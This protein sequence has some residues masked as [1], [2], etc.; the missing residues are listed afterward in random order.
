MAKKLTLS[1]ADDVYAALH[2]VVGQG[3]ISQFVEALVRPYLGR[4]KRITPAEGRGIAR[5]AGPAKSA[6]EIRA[7]VRSGVRRKWARR[8]GRDAS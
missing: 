8:L 3:N 1:V 6:A 7:G 4:F 2:Q 5:Y